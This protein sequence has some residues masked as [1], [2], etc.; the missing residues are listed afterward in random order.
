ML[1][2]IK[3]QKIPQKMIHNHEVPGSIP[4]PATEEVN[5][6]QKCNSFFFLT[7][8]SDVRIG[9]LGVR[10]DVICIVVGIINAKD[11]VRKW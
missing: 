10:A 5:E 4:G 11:R 2:F 9:G 7:R 8:E 3:V 1:N 6:L